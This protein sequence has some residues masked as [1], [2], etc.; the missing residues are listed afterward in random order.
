MLPA[1]A[2]KNETDQRKL[3]EAVKRWLEQCEQQWLLI[4]DNADDVSIIQKYLPQRG[5]G[6]VL[7]T[8]RANAVGS[9]AVL[10][11]EVEK[12]GLMEGTQFLLHRAQRIEHTSDDEINEVTNIVI[13]LD[14]FPLALDQ[15]GA[16][17]E[18]TQVRSVHA[19]PWQH[20]GCVAG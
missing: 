10:S 20:G 1:S 15:A 9:L 14:H 6:S 7:L 5:N 2:A 4:F 17:I 19:K 8:T 11:I 18:E 13:A 12:M 16:Y 3:V